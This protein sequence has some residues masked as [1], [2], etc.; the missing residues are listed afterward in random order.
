[1][2]NRAGKIL[3]TGGAGFIGSVVT[4]RLLEAG[5]SVTVLDDLSTGFRDAVPDGAEF[6]K[7]RIQEAEKVLDPSYSAVLHLAAFAEVGES[8][9]VPERYWW[10]NTL[11]T[12]AL[13][14]AMRRA[15]VRTL[16]FSSTCAVYG[17][18]QKT[19]LTE[20]TPTDPINPYGSSK[21]A[22]DR[23][24]A[25]ECLAHGL[26]AVS[27]RYFNV[28]GAYGAYGERHAPESHLIP[29]T[30]QVAQGRRAAILVHGSDYPT[31]DGTCVRDYVH[32]ADIAGAHLRSLAVARPGRHLICNLGSGEG[33]SVR[34]VIE[35]V[36]EL[37]GHPVP[38]ADGARRAGD[39]AV[40]V[41]SAER[42]HRELGWT[43]QRTT[44]RQMIRDAWDFAQRG[45]V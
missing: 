43:P 41:A 39:P 31:A 40:L 19:P 1:V 18:P 32:V 35:G 27:L 15:G 12:F 11:G 28:A 7:G 5:H 2:N 42:A 13:L 8:V 29:L 4:A 22:A 14:Q 23:M 26:A 44:L 37:T 10:N 36:R 9:R 3:V 6:L 34:Q 24:I 30:L 33:Y 17:E 45:H 38:T 16:V 21:L 25:D 20:D